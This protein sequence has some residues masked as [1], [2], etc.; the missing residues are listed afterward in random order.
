VADGVDGWCYRA[1]PSILAPLIQ[2]LLTVAR[3][4]EAQRS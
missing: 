2:R 3:K 4:I 1:E